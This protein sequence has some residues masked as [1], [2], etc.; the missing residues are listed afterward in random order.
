MLRSANV[1]CLKNLTVTRKAQICQQLCH[2]SALAGNVK[3]AQA[4]TR[5]IYYQGSHSCSRSLLQPEEKKK[6]KHASSMPSHIV[7]IPILFI[8]A[9]YLPSISTHHLDYCTLRSINEKAPFENNDKVLHGFH[10]NTVVVV[11]SV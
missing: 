11:L 1:R 9:L 7:W 4:H 10:T 2:S 3:A 5:D 6:K 8:H